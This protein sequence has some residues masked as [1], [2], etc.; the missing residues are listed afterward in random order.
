MSNISLW[1]NDKG[2]YPDEIIMETEDKITIVY[3]GQKSGRMDKF[4][5]NGNYMFIKECKKYKFL[6]NVTMV[7]VLEKEQNEIIKKYLLVVD[8]NKLNLSFKTKNEACKHFGWSTLNKF[9]VMSGIICHK[10]C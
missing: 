9:E 10:N 7:K 4:I 2:E 8:K 3:C 5:S 1:S 6:G